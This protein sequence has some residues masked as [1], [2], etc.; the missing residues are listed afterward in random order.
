MAAISELRAMILA[1]GR[2]ERLR[3]LTDT[4]PKPLVV[5]GGRPLI[6]YALERVADAGIRR[7]VINLHHLGHLIRDHV[8]DGSRFGLAVDY[9]E[10]A[11]LQDTGGGIRDARRYLDGSTFLTLNA[12]TIVD[13]DLRDLA[14]SHRTSGAIATMLLRKDPQMDRFG[15]IETED[16]GRVGRFL[17]QP[18]PGCHEPLE[19]YMYTGVQ[20]LEPGVFGYLTGEGPFSITKVSYPAMLAAGELVRG[21]VFDGTWITVGTPAELARAD[22]ILGS[23][24]L[25]E[26]RWTTHSVE[27]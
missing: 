3:P 26:R 7:V 13:V 23:R 16:D 10:E 6:D 15:L 8:G 11:I 21:R 1:A 2:G 20:V 27:S 24:V 17:G 19:A 5:V 12:D 9:S 22:A 14:E 4:V 25:S 18:R